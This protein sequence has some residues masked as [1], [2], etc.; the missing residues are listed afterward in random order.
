MAKKSTNSKTVFAETEVSKKDNKFYGGSRKVELVERIKERSVFIR[1]NTF[2]EFELYDAFN[3][4]S[5]S[6]DTISLDSTIYRHIEFEKVVNKEGKVEIT[7]RF[8]KDENFEDKLSEIEKKI[9]EVKKE[10]L[11]LKNIYSDLEK[12]IKLNNIKNTKKINSLR[13]FIENLSKPDNSIGL[14][15]GHIYLDTNDSKKGEE[16]FA[17]LNIFLNTLNLEIAL[18]DEA[19]IGSWIKK[20]VGKINNFFTSEEL[21]DRFKDFEH[22]IQLKNIDKVQSEIDLNQATAAAKLMDSLKDTKNC[23][24]MIGSVILIKY[25]NELGEQIQLCKTLTRTELKTISK[26]E[27]ILNSPSEIYKLI[28]KNITVKSNKK[29]I[30]K[31]KIQ[32]DKTDLLT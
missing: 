24:I 18:E 21:K 16:I 25:V 27:S 20:F 2:G 28:N 6:D 23:A 12:E 13:N 3:T 7:P 32:I 10:N 14:F 8:S 31:T 1:K 15:H 11:R 4:M 5:N 9:T 17:N 26:N 22:A 19:I 29:K 30:Q